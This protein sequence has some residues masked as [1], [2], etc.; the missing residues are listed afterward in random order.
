[1]VEGLGRRCGLSGSVDLCVVVGDGR[2]TVIQSEPQLVALCQAEHPRLVGLML[3]YVHD[4]DV[5]EELAQ[6][7]LVRLC[8]RWPRVSG[9][10][11]PA[12]WLMTVATNLARSSLR[13]RAAEQRARRRHGP[14]TPPP[15]SPVDPGTVLEI[16]QAV[17]ALPDRQRVAIAYRYY[18]GLSVRETA[19]AMQ[20]AEGT[21]R[22]LTSQGLAGLRDAGLDARDDEEDID[23]YT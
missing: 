17:R 20:I 2:G 16:R 15:P 22:A 19:A 23:A 12:A 8:E 3:L 18:A 10:D 11:N 21:V 4:R 13:R 5:A 7:A 9:M 6:E 14:T 1:M